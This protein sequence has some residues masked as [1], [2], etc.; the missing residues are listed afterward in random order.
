MR[1]GG[2]LMTQEQVRLICLKIHTTSKLGEDE[3]LAVRIQT[4]AGEQMGY[5]TFDHCPQGI[6]CL[7]RASITTFID[8]TKIISIEPISA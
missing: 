3:F 8:C 6:V 4:D 1:A 5:V 2:L 7:V